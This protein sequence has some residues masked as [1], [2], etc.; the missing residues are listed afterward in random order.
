MTDSTLCE[1]MDLTELAHGDRVYPVMYCRL[2]IRGHFDLKRLKKSIEQSTQYI[3]EIL[4]SLDFKRCRF[5]KTHHTV[6][7]VFF[8]ETADNRGSAEMV[9]DGFFDENKKAEF[10]SGWDLAADTQLKIFIERKRDIWN[11]TIGMSHALTDGAG[12]LQYLYL[13]ASI[14]NG[15]ALPDGLKNVRSMDRVIKKI[16]FCIGRNRDPVPQKSICRCYGG[17]QCYC[18][19]C[20]VDET[21]FRRVC[22]KAEALKVS[23]NDVLMTAYAR[24][25]A[26][27]LGEMTVCI[28]CPADLRR[29]GPEQG[30]TIGNMT[31][32]YRSVPVSAGEADSFESTLLQIHREL[33][34]QKKDRQCFQGIRM[35]RR[36]YRVLPAQCVVR[37]IR[38]NYHI[39]PLSYTNIGR[40]D[41]DRLYFADCN[42]EA[43]YITG[44]Y[45]K[46]PDFQLSVSTFKNVCTLNCTLSGSIQRKM[47]GEILLEEIRKE[48]V[49]WLNK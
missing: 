49:G 3:P 41:S 16:P 29:E 47:E 11:L 23:I 26:R 31:G 14:Y 8:D 32:L 22:M 45:R 19:C 5:V 20:S 37:L 2:V 46:A 27:R 10:I 33:R 28:P 18:L 36:L 34:R 9:N 38:S 40:I 43:C 30:L 6:D 25:A 21:D 13:L 12:F 15:A 48:L 17:N 7:D 39:N 4:Y 1:Y 44:T 24:T 35:L 42:T